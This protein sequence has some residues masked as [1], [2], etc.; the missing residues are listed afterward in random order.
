VAPSDVVID[1][2]SLVSVAGSSVAV[3][4][5]AAQHAVSRPERYATTT[6]SGGG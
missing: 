2:A 4:A 3:A 5:A 1:M 6:W